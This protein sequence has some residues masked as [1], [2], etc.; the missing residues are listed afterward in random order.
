LK[1]MR[2]RKEKKHGG[3][4]MVDS[5]EALESIFVT[6]DLVEISPT[7]KLV[8]VESGS[9]ETS[10]NNER[11]LTVS[12][13]IDGKLKK[14]RPNKESVRNLQ[15]FGKDTANWVSKPINLKV[16][17][18]LGKKSVIAMPAPTQ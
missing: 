8:V 15:V 9:Y 18:R 5:G 14:W 10:L 13:N 4:N 17:Y 11:R 1:K 6:A 12:V 7:K 16:E 2:K 3:I